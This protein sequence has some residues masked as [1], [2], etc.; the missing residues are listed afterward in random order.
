MVGKW[1]SKLLPNDSI[2]TSNHNGIHL[3]APQQCNTLLHN[4]STQCLEVIHRHQVNI[5][6]IQQDNSSNSLAGVPPNNSSINTT[7]SILN[8]SSH[9]NSGHHPVL[10][11][12]LG[13][14]N[15]RNINNLALAI[16]STRTPTL[17]GSTS[18]AINSTMD[19]LGIIKADEDLALPNV[20]DT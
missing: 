4:L 8:N 16:S 20:E 2:V 13:H 17:K 15:R 1:Y 7:N 18:K 5:L 12:L 3:T 14:H 10:G 11:N 9:S 6:H 19:T